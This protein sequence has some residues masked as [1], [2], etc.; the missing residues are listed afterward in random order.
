[1][2]KPHSRAEVIVG[3]QPHVPIGTVDL[4]FE[5]R[6]TRFGNLEKLLGDGF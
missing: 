5:G 4:S 2:E 1:M 3:K 6:F